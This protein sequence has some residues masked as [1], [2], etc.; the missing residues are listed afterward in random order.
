MARARV[1]EDDR[2]V[3]DADTRVDVKFDFFRKGRDAK[4]SYRKARC[5]EIAYFMNHQVVVRIHCSLFLVTT[6][7]KAKNNGW[8]SGLRIATLQTSTRGSITRLVGS[9]LLTYLTMSM[10]I[11]HGQRVVF[12]S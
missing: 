8:S 1:V 9:L 6:R 4:V 3:L 12:N 5:W 7:R 10:F 11:V 2:L